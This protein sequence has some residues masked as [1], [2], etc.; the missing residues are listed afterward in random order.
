MILSLPLSR[1]SGV[2]EKSSTA[3]DRQ[4]TCSIP[5]SLLLLLLLRLLTSLIS[6][7]IG[8]PRLWW[9]ET[10]KTP[11]YRLLRVGKSE[12]LGPLGAGV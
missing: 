3:A 2:L 8:A 6:T 1:W 4:H 11:S 10:L 5:P 12:P 9:C 7:G